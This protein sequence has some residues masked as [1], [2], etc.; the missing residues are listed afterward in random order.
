MGRSFRVAVLCAALALAPAYALG[1]VDGEVA[2]VW[3]QNE[4][5]STT[6][7]ASTSSDAGAPGLRA[8]LWVLQRYG[9]R[10]SQWG[11]NPDGSDGADY[12]SVDVMWRAL[13]PTE[14]NFL[15]LG[16]GWQQMDVEG[17]GHSTDGVR[18]AIEGRVGLL[19]VLQGYAAGAYTPSL[20]DVPVV[21]PTA[22]RFEELDAYEY[23]LGVAWNALPFMDVHAG[24][25]V[26]SLSFMR[27]VDPSPSG[28][29]TQLFPVGGGSG[30]SKAAPAS[31]GGCPG[32]SSNATTWDP[33]DS[34]AQSS[35]F[36]LGLGVHF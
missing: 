30:T 5:D 31:G 14:N 36:F 11:S 33:G 4:F 18:M 32:C 22:G 21:M 24:Y 7:S 28:T 15:A 29:P 26:N 35:G 34:E 2:T 9:L 6:S 23:E 16:V 10:A 12:S 19:T 3:W 25:R 20:S 17:L 8:Q 1:P 27:T 13:A